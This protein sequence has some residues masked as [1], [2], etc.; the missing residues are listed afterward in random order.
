MIFFIHKKCHLLLELSIFLIYFSKIF[1]GGLSFNT[2]EGIYNENKKSLIISLI[3]NFYYYNLAA[4]KS[5]F[6]KYGTVTSVIV[7]RDQNTMKSRGFGF[8]VFASSKAAQQAIVESR[9]NIDGKMVEVKAAVP[10]D[11]D[12]PPPIAQK[13]S[14]GRKIFVGG[15]HYETK[16][17]SLKEYFSQYGSV[18]SVQIM[19]NKETNKSRGFG[20]V[21]FES[22][23]SVEEVIKNRLHIIDNK[24]VEVKEAVP[25]KDITPPPSSNQSH[26]STQP[27]YFFIFYLEFQHHHK[28]NLLNIHIIQNQYIV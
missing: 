6:E 15:L 2:T 12:P 27:Q 5:Y 7:M 17:E 4:L 14:G 8:C 1:V 23:C 11:M 16:E 20:F 10:K 22:P 3:Y 28:F 26:H 21:T 18:E 13:S 9:H 19:M 25:K 24:E